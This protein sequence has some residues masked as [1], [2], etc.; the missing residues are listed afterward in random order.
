[1]KNKIVW[2]VVSCLMAL[3]LFVVSCEEETKKT[4]NVDEGDDQVKITTSEEN[5]AVGGE[6]KDQVVETPKGP[7][8]GGTIKIATAL[9]PGGFDEVY[10][11]AANALT[12]KLTHQE[13]MMGD[14]T[15]G[16]AGTGEVDW[17][18]GAIRKISLSTGCLAESWEFPEVGTVI[19][20]IREGVH[21]AMD[22][23]NQGSVPIRG[24]PCIMV[25]LSSLHLNSSTI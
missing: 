15:L 21:F 14:W 6:E 3:S 23:Y 24:Q 19:F 11:V 20:H 16:P 9:Q 25:I 8:Y 13:L 1:M 18:G 7:Q 4:T 12:M 5:I 2:V 10:S 17:A 22:P